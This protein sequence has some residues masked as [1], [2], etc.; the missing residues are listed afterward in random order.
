MVER[1][2]TSR[3]R[4]LVAT[5]GITSA[6][7]SA[8]AAYHIVVMRVGMSWNT[9]EQRYFCG[10]EFFLHE[11]F[12]ATDPSHDC[13]HLLIAAN[14]DMPWN[15]TG[16]K[17]AF[18]RTVE[19]NASVLEHLLDETFN[20]CVY[21]A[22]EA[23]CLPKVVKYAHWFVEE[24]YKP[25]PVSAKQALETFCSKL[26]KQTIV[27]LS[28][29]FFSMK[30]SERQ[31]PRGFRGGHIVL[32]FEVDDPPPVDH[33]IVKIQSFLREQLPLLTAS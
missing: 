7:A 28:P 15:P 17:N 10:D 19:Y 3:L 12:T 29:H 26:N 24:H 31:N 30:R 22:P 32:E 1:F 33:E 27:R 4:D 13:A 23:E 2:T 20:C 11:G 25:F 9:K 8:S 6:S 18:V 21:R 5:P 14:G 16:E